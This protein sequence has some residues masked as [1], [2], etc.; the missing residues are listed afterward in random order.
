MISTRR[1]AAAGGVA[2]SIALALSGCGTTEVA[3]TETVAD[4][5]ASQSCADDT[6]ETSTEPVSL[7]DGVGR[8]VELDRPAERIVVLE[9]QEV[10]DA[11]TL[12]VTPVAVADPTGYGT[13]V[14]AEELPDGVVDIGS[15]EEPDFDALF[16]TDPDL[17]VVEAFTADDE[18][19]QQLEQYDVPVVAALGNDPADPIGN[20]KEVFSLIAEV[21]GRTER[22]EQVLAEFDAHLAQR[23]QDVAGLDLPTTDFL[24]FDG[25][26]Q[27]GNL[28]IRPYVEGSLFT[29]LGQELGLTPAWDSAVNESYGTGGLNAEYGLAQTDVEGLTGVGEAN[30]FFSNGDASGYVAELEK[31]SIWTSLPAVQEGRAYEFPLIWGAGGPRSTMQAIDAFADALTQE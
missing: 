16:A 30:L 13:W 1:T 7:V 3:E 5:P 29:A 11:L 12:C 8:T 21:T 17:I 24:F 20:V 23:K 28:T 27:G 19:I 25:W 22:A 6:T 9:W 26:V 15:R 2:L 31:S 18:F 14:S 4:A 10:E